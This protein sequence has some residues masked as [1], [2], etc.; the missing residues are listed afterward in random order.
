MHHLQHT[1]GEYLI[2]SDKTLLQ[3]RAVHQWLTEESYWARG[4]P[5]DTVKTS[6]D[7]SWTMGALHEGRQVAYARMITDYATFAYLA[8]VYV[9]EPHRGKGLSKVMLQLLMDQ[10]WVKG[11]RRIML[12]SLDAQVLY[13][14]YGFVKPAFPERFMEITRPAIYRKEPLQES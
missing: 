12:A 5:Y 4:I 6:F 14:R 7:N 9:E 8:D 10:D 2:T 3:P 11:L 13:E 1:F